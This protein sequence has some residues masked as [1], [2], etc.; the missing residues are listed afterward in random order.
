M[1]VP[2]LLVGL[3][4]LLLTAC[5]AESVTRVRIEPDGMASVISEGAFDEEALQL[6]GQTGDTP[7][8]VLGSLADIIDPSLLPVPV[9]DAA[10]EQFSRGELQGLRIE[11]D[12]LNA[13]E[14]ARQ[15][16]SNNS[17]IEDVVFEVADGVLTVSARSRSVSDFERSRLQAL[18]PG[19]LSEILTLVLQ[20]EVPGMVTE[21]TA[22]RV[23]AD[24]V[25]EW[26]LL[27]AITEGRSVAVSLIADVDPAFQF[28]D[29]D[30]RPL[31]EAAEQ[32]PEESSSVSLILV[33]LAVVIAAG[34]SFLIIRRLQKRR[35]SEIEGFTPRG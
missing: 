27:P 9:E 30:G 24:G 18:A 17:I 8:D 14:I 28:M 1:R 2:L 34:V 32:P 6:I 16:A 5:R 20:V 29:L 12:G 7:A 26:D 15:I 13:D 23:L 33:G 19:D 21:H 35:L 31:S 11:L 3:L 25:L 4:A 10:V 22:D